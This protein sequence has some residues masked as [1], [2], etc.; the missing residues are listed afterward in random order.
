MP[1]PVEARNSN[2]HLQAVLIV[3][4]GVER[5]AASLKDD[6]MLGT[7]QAPDP[8][9]YLLADHLD[10]ALAA[11]EDLLAQSLEAPA[12]IDRANTDADTTDA[13]ADAI[14]AFV[15]NLKRHEASMI[16][17]VLQ[18]RRRARE[19]PKLEQPVRG[20]INLLQASTAGALDLVD[21]FSDGAEGAQENSSG[22]IYGFLRSRGLL[23]AEAATL[24]RY[25][26]VTVSETYR[27]GGVLEVG[28][29]LN[30]IAAALDALDLHYDLYLADDDTV[31]VAALADD[32]TG[33]DIEAAEPERAEADTADTKDISEAAKVAKEEQADTAAQDA[34][35][36]QSAK[37]GPGASDAAAPDA[38][39]TSATAGAAVDVVSQATKEE[40]GKGSKP[41]LT[42]GS[43]AAAL[44]AVKDTASP[45]AN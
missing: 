8:G 34:V 38:A 19:L 39:A 27:V 18:A 23:A 17:R 10:A 30:A 42:A 44:A 24:P 20:M 11:G 12:E 25:E 5:V 4:A 43:L 9:I 36:V 13:S 21:H 41:A 28:P 3:L 1:D 26:Q 22:T 35:D 33:S 37:A 31:G 29:L 7:T 16:A 40:A 15:A 45:P 14:A 2:S 32:E 6:A